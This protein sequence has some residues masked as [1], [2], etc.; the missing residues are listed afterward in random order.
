MISR[1]RILKALD[2]QESDRIPRDL[3]GTESS[4]MTANSL[5]K[6]CTYLHIPT[7][8]KIFEPYQYV[9]YIT[10]ELKEKFKI[11][12]A[13]L[14]IEPRNWMKQINPF[15][16]EV[17]L[18]REW[19][20]ETCEDESTL[21]R[22]KDG[23]VVA[24]R[25]KDGHYFDTVNPPLETITEPGLMAQYKETI[26]SFDLPSFADE[27]VEHLQSRAE[28]LYKRDKCTCGQA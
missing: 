18:P 4:G 3:G 25:P 8:L 21:V 11:D 12:T 28:V 5:F 26:F 23:K 9:A 7:T 13:N 2:H 27:S 6:L 17:I 10:D 16:F 22:S 14:T 1:E 24:R 19:H 15:N 20:E